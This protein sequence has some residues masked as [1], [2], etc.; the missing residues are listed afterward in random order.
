MKD[1]LEQ[2][3]VRN[4]LHKGDERHFGAKSVRNVLHRGDERHF[5]AKSGSKCPS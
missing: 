3:P 5:G 4:V 2:N 1:I